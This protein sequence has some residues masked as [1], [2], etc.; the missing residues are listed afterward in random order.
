MIYISKT[1]QILIWNIEQVI[2][3]NP[4]NL[5]IEN[6]IKLRFISKINLIENTDFAIVTCQIELFIINQYTLQIQKIIDIDVF[7]YIQGYTNVFSRY[8]TLSNQ[9]NSLLVSSTKGIQVWTLDLIA[10]DHEYYGIISSTLMNPSQNQIKQFIKHPNYDMIICGGQYLEVQFVQIINAQQL[11]FYQIFLNRFLPPNYNWISVKDIVLIPKDL[12]DKNSQDLILFNFQYGMFQLKANFLIDQNNI[13]QIVNI[14]TQFINNSGLGWFYIPQYQLIVSGYYYSAYLYNIQQQT[15][16]QLLQQSG[17]GNNKR[18][19]ITY[20]NKDYQV[21]IN[22]NGFYVADRNYIG[23][24]V[25]Q[26]QNPPFPYVQNLGS[27]LSV[28]YCDMCFF[29]I[30]NQSGSF[31]DV[32]NLYFMV[33]TAFPINSAYQYISLKQ[34]NLA[35][36]TMPLNLDPYYYENAVWVAVGIYYTSNNS[37]CIFLLLNIYD[38]NIHYC[39]KSPNPNDNSLESVYAIPSLEDSTNQEIVGITRKGIVFRWD[40]KSK[41]YKEQIQIDSLM[42]NI[43]HHIKEDKSIYKYFFAVCETFYTVVLDLQTKQSIILDNPMR[44]LSKTMSMFETIGLVAIGSN[45]G[46]TYLYRY[47][48]KNSNFYLFMQLGANKLIE[49][50]LFVTLI[51]KNVLWIQ[52]QFRYLYYSIDQCLE[53]V[54]NCLNCSFDFYYQTSEAQQGTNYYGQ[55]TQDIPF[56]SSNHLLTAILK[57]Q[58]YRDTVKAVTNIETIINIQT[59]YPFQLKEEFLNFN[60]NQQISL[61]IKSIIKGQKAQIFTNNQL[62]FANYNSINIQDIDFIFDLKNN[63]QATCGFSFNNLTSIVLDNISS[64]GQNVANKINCYQFTVLNSYFQLYNYT[65]QN[66]SLEQITNLINV[67]QS[68][69]IFIQNL[70]IDN[71]KL[72][73]GFSIINSQSDIFFT[74]NNINITKNQPS[75]NF[76]NQSISSLF[77]AGQFNLSDINI[78]F[79]TLINIKIFSAMPSLQQSNYTF[80]IQN[81]NMMENIFKLNSDHILFNALYSQLS[82]PDHNFIFQNG[83]FFRNQ[84]IYQNQLVSLINDQNTTSFLIE[85]INIKNVQLHNINFSN[86]YE[87]SFMKL[88]NAFEANITHYNCFDILDQGNQIK[89]IAGCL[90]LKDIQNT[91]LN[92]IKFY[93]K[94]CKDISLL[95]ITNQQYENTS[96]LITKGVF[97]YLNLQQ[98]QPSSQLN[99]L[100]I[101]SQQQSNITLQYCEFQQNI[102]SSPSSV[103]INSVTSLWI[104]NVLGNTVISNSKF[105]NSTSNSLYNFI[106]IQSS[107]LQIQNCLFDQS[108]FQLKSQLIES[109]NTNNINQQ[110]GFIRAN[111][112][113]LIVQ[114]TSCS[115][116]VSQKGSFIYTE[117]FGQTLNISISNSNFSNGYSVVDGS[118]LY[119]DITNQNFFFTCEECNFFNLYNYQQQSSAIAF[120]NKAQSQLNNLIKFSRGSIQNITGLEYGYFIKVQGLS[121]IFENIQK[122]SNQYAFENNFNVFQSFIASYNSTIQFIGCQIS[123]QKLKQL[124]P[125]LIDS[126]L[127]SV[128]ISQTIFQDSLFAYSFI[129][130]DQGSLQILNSTFKNIQQYSQ[131]KQIPNRVLQGEKLS[132]NSNSLIKILSGTLA[133]RN[134]TLFQSIECNQMCSGSAFQI[135]NSDFSLQNAIFQDLKS[136]Q[137]GAIYIQSPSSVNEID[138]CLFKNN[139]SSQNGGALIILTQ[140]GNKYKIYI[141]N[142]QFINNTSLNGQ[143]GAFYI[144]SDSLNDLN[145]SILLQNSAVTSNKAQQG[146]AL[147]SFN[148]YPIIDPLTIMQNNFAA[149]C[150]QDTFSFPTKLYLA[151][152]D[153]FLLSQQNSKLINDK[154]V[155]SNFKSGSGLQELRFQMFNEQNELFVP[156]NNLEPYYAYVQIS[157]KTVNSNNFYIRGQVQQKYVI[158]EVPQ[159][160]SITFNSL[161]IIGI[162]GSIGI[163][164]FYSNQ[165]FQLEPTTNKFI[166]NQTYEIII[167][168]RNCTAGEYIS[169]YNSYQEC[170]NCPQGTYSIDPKV[171]LNCPDGATCQEGKGIICK[172][173]YWRS[174][175]Y[176]DQVVKCKQSAQNCIGGSYGN[177]ICKKGSIGALCQECDV[178]GSYWEQEQYT[179]ASNQKDCVH[180]SEAKDYIYKLILINLWSL[181]SLVYT[182]AKNEENTLMRRTSIILTKY[183]K[184][185]KKKDKIEKEVKSQASYQTNPMISN[186]IGI[187]IKLFMNYIF[188]ISSLGQLN[189]DLPN[190]LTV[191]PSL[192]GRPVSTQVSSLECF[193]VGYNRN[194][195][196]IY[197]KLIFSLSLPLLHFILFV[198]YLII[199][200]RIDKLKQFPWHKVTTSIL[201]IVIYTQPDLISYMISLSSCIQIGKNK[202]I[203]ANFSYQCY[204]DEDYYKYTYYLVFPC[205]IL[206][207]VALPMA[208]FLIL[209]LNKQRLQRLNLELKFGFIYKEYKINAYYWEFVK[210]FIKIIIILCLNFY[211]Q[212][213]LVKGNLILVSIIFYSYLLKTIKPY[214]EEEVNHIDYMSTLICAISIYLG[215]FISEISDNFTYYQYLAYIIIAII[216]M[217]FIGIIFWKIF[218]QKIEIFYQKIKKL[219]QIF[220]KCKKNNKIQKQINTPS[221]QRFKQSFQTFLKSNP[222]IRKNRL[223]FI[224]NQIQTR[225]L[226][227]KDQDK[228]K[229]KKDVS[230]NIFKVSNEEN[231]MSIIISPKNQTSQEFQIDK[232]IQNDL[233]S[234]NSI[235]QDLNSQSQIFSKQKELCSHRQDINNNSSQINYQNIIDLNSNRT[236]NQESPFLISASKISSQIVKPQTNND[237]N[238]L[239][240]D[241]FQV[242]IKDIN[243]DIL[244]DRSM[245]N[246][247][248][249]N[250]ENE[251]SNRIYQFQKENIFEVYCIQCPNLVTFQSITSDVF[252]FSKFH[253]QYIIGC[254]YFENFQPSNFILIPKTSILILNTVSQSNS[255]NSILYY[256]DLQSTEFQMHYIQKIDQI[257]AWNNE[258]VILAN[259]YTLNPQNQVFFQY[260]NTINLIE[261]SDFAV[262]TMGLEIYIINQYNLSIIKI[263]D[264]Y[265]NYFIYNYWGLYSSFFVLS[266]NENVLLVQTT[267]GIQAWTFDLKS[268]DHEHYG[269]IQQTFQNNQKQFVKHPK[270]DMIII[271]IVYGNNISLQFIQID[272][273]V[274]NEYTQFY[275]YLYQQQSSLQVIGMLIIPKDQNDINSKDKLLVNYSTGILSIDMEFSLDQKQNIQNTF[276]QVYSINQGSS[277]WLYLYDQNQLILGYQFYAYLIDIKTQSSTQMLQYASDGNNRRYIFEYQNSQYYIY[278]NPHGFIVTDRDYNNRR[279]LYKTNPPKPY[280][281]LKHGTFFQ[282]KGCELCYVLICNESGNRYD[283]NNLYI[284][285][286]LAFPINSTYQVKYQFYILENISNINLNKQYISL[287]AHNIQINT[288]TYNLDPFFYNNQVW[289]TIGVSYTQNQLGCVF[290]LLNIQ[291]YNQYFCLSSTN[292][293]DNQLESMFAIVSLNDPNN[294]EIVG[295]TRNGIVFKW[296][297]QNKS[298]TGRILIPNCYDSQSG[299]MYHYVQSDQSIYK[300]FIVVCETFQA[301]ILDLQTEQVKIIDFKMRAMNRVVNVFEQ[302]GIIAFGGNFEITYLFKY[303]HQ[304]KQF[305]LF[306][307]IGSQ[308]LLEQVFFIQLVSQNTLWIQYTFRDLYLPLDTCLQDVN[309]CLNCSLDYYYQITE[310]QQTNKFYGLGTA[311]QPFSSSNNLF[312]GILKAQ[313]YTDNIVGVVNI[314]TNIFINPEKVFQIKNQ[315][316]SFDFNQKIS[317]KIKSLRDGYQA[318]VITLN[319]LQFYNY[320]SITFQD[321]N[322]VFDLQ[323]LQTSTCGLVFKNVQNVVL[324]NIQA[325]AQNLASKSNFYLISVNN[326]FLQLLNYQLKNKIL[327]QITE[328]I[329]IKNSNQVLIQNFTLDSCQLDPGFTIMNSESDIFFNGAQINILNNNTTLS[330]QNQMISALFIAGQYNLTNININN[331]TFGN[332]K[333]FDSIPLQ[334]QVNY[335]FQF[336]NLQM[337]SNQFILNNQNLLFSVLYTQLSQPEHNLFLYNGTFYNN[338][339]TSVNQQNSNSLA[340]SSSAKSY[341]IQTEKIKNIQIRNVNFSNHNEISFIQSLYTS[342]MNISQFNFFSTPTK[343]QKQTTI[344]GCFQVQEIQNIQIV[345]LQVYDINSQD[346][347]L[348]LLENEIYKDA[349]ILIDRS[350]FTNLSLMQLLPSSNANPIQILTQQKS[351]IVFQNCIFKQIMLSSPA[352]ALTYSVTSIWVQNVLGNTTILSSQFYKF[353]SN[354]KYNSLYIQTQSLS[355]QNSFFDEFQVQNKQKLILNQDQSNIIT[356]GGFIRANVYD[357]QMKNISCSNSIGFKGSFIYAESYGQGLS[358]NISDSN[359]TEGYSLSDGSAF[360]FDVS[361]INFQ[362]VCSNCNFKNFFNFQTGSSVIAFSNISSIQKTQQVYINYGLIYNI[363]GYQYGYF[364]KANSLLLSFQ[365][366]SQIRN[367]KQTQSYSHQDQSLIYSYKSKVYFFNC[368]LDNFFMR[369]LNPLLINSQASQITLEKTSLLNSE[370]SSTFISINQGQLN[371]VNSSFNNINQI[372]QANEKRRILQS[373]LGQSVSSNSLIQIINAT[374]QINSDSIFNNL[375]CNQNCYGSSLKI[376]ES[377]FYIQNAFFSNLQAT[378]GGAIYIENAAQNNIISN[379]EFKNNTS[380]LDG[381]ALM[382]YSSAS[383]E[384]QLNVNS[385]KF[386][387]NQSIKGKGGAIYVY[388]DSLNDNNQKIFIVNSN[389]TNNKAQIG[390][391]IQFQNNSPDID[392]KTVIYNNK[393][394]SYGQNTY[395]NPTKLHFINQNDFLNKYPGSKMI[396]DSVL[397]LTNFK[398]GSNL[399]S[400]Y[401]QMVNEQNELVIPQAEENPYYVKVRI[402][403]QID[404]QT[405]YQIRGQQSSKYVINSIPQLSTVQFD[406]IQVIGI[407]GSMGIIEF[408][409]DQ[410]FRVDPQTNQLQQD[411]V[412]KIQIF[413]RNCTAGE[414]IN[415]YSNYQECIYCPIGTYSFDP[416]VCLDCPSGAVCEPGKG[417]TCQ[418]GFWRSSELDNQILECTYSKYNCVG[419][420]YGNHICRRGSIGALCQECDIYGKY[421]DE[422]YTKQTEQN[423]CIPCSESN[424]YLYKLILIQL[425]VIF[426]LAFIVQKNEENTQQYRVSNILIKYFQKRSSSMESSVQE[427]NKKNDVILNKSEIYAKIF[428]NYIFI[429][430]VIGTL[431]L[432]IPKQILLLPNFL[433]KPLYTSVSALECY[434]ASLKTE[435]PPYNEEELLQIEQSS[436]LT[437]AISIYLGVFIGSSDVLKENMQNIRKKCGYLKNK[438]FIKSNQQAPK[439]QQVKLSNKQLQ[440]KI[441]RVLSSLLQYSKEEKKQILISLKDQLQI[442]NVKCQSI[443]QSKRNINNNSLMGNAKIQNSIQSKN[444]KASISDLDEQNNL[445]LEYFRNQKQFKKFKSQNINELLR[446]DSKQ[447]EEDAQTF[448]N[449]ILTLS[450]ASSDQQPIILNFEQYSKQEE[451]IQ[452]KNT[453]SLN[454]QIQNNINLDSNNFN[455]QEETDI[456]IEEQNNL[457]LNSLHRQFNQKELPKYPKYTKKINKKSQSQ[458]YSNTAEKQVQNTFFE[459]SFSISSASSNQ[460]KKI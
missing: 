15:T 405:N 360:Y 451:Q 201:F 249:E 85:N 399:S 314:N 408:Y 183:F 171:C 359:F 271:S 182:V 172:E 40:M 309:N 65:L 177:K 189:L 297:L 158:N 233:G 198:F 117:S 162:P 343:S 10:F 109:K 174:G 260:I 94:T 76:Q 291:D 57:A 141:K 42:G 148:I 145:Q 190:T 313:Q 206:W 373:D 303:D 50:V 66:K 59:S 332:F 238:L 302:I 92:Q 132:Q 167:L 444:I 51:P 443:Q 266:N 159:L 329:H 45:N 55:G 121:V 211:S 311:S 270:Y 378:E 179:K 446:Q 398:S 316:L 232:S 330:M 282:V 151:N 246:I 163:I 368:T 4:Y 82:N 436:T 431:K 370:F 30:C 264:A 345:Q 417:L 229:F 277:A 72:D 458:I 131:L 263:F 434:L 339:Y 107:N 207:I 118:A 255:Q 122:I 430:S 116:S 19:M 307:Q 299:N 216:N 357:L 382:I 35:R 352:S 412:F 186:K 240:S 21:Y 124:Y 108:S 283:P 404:N 18:Y 318:Q 185:E 165:I 348:I 380:I 98:N 204:A 214:K 87:I 453:Q 384:Y 356:E 392:D 312:T 377:T 223:E 89:T 175:E 350:N 6:Q 53:N 335:T 191:F 304:N 95:Q 286:T 336:Y 115:N 358:I 245:P 133:V 99:P 129:T 119:F 100:Q 64:A 52:S 253:Y 379:C 113:N 152:Q 308:K 296:D 3:A 247:P 231:I 196:I 16:T 22:S 83:N 371:I 24:K 280:V 220:K 294:Q 317:L 128:T 236:L 197:L 62:S 363:T 354:S 142:S 54:E 410:I 274:N 144:Y 306:M 244:S 105:Q 346:I 328:L 79:N 293:S 262:I 337:N 429:I 396:N 421:W 88:Q 248:Q 449:H 268:Y 11:S 227:E 456:N 284:A 71:C 273:V 203:L 154:I 86:H 269:Y 135:Q 20:Q 200:S 150:G 420:S 26:K 324:D 166:Q 239:K 2:L 455:V 210:M 161:Q 366:V 395:S 385:C 91:N 235:K 37:G 394:K 416:K 281:Q 460:E 389:I 323:N 208:L 381:G 215:V 44:S 218:E 199:Q 90:L 450:P 29:I 193:L 12:K 439:S 63:I 70:V 390:G 295:I 58:Q 355:L 213:T 301:N 120:N 400:I 168:F 60:F 279:T 388:S 261:N 228:D 137:G 209:F 401:F 365:N 338:S 173:G 265:L 257:L 241:L 155:I 427:E 351:S 97:N 101:I 409:S 305:N 103:L 1:D 106:Y 212:N 230:Q 367:Q 347:S 414:F 333:V 440:L 267:V 126:Q 362:M 437:I 138:N 426:S 169:Q 361:N 272:S 47:D 457:Q 181:A 31:Y 459:N 432:N 407:P 93:N 403:N 48:A 424:E 334:S 221:K 146:G 391:G 36:N 375:S 298:N 153:Q 77:Q 80:Q 290:K 326:G 454:S 43:Y 251:P 68:K 14:N 8:I 157:N 402:S 386:T 164:E 289:V 418:E 322:I 252:N 34:Y 435:V 139:T 275:S 226:E 134:N 319:Q 447:Q 425:F 327:S 369:Q 445:Q 219:L 340:Y 69:Q 419:G 256:I 127:S 300:Y 33:T 438:Y 353:Q 156:S 27:F 234:K 393:A 342:Q 194:I 372:N 143:G 73:P 96:I 411:Y 5:D 78:S 102:L 285:T 81:I 242:E 13:I 423:D 39:L 413:F 75:Q 441:Q 325:T 254:N 74:G 136:V 331:N 364:I 111:V 217:I 288:M 46:L 278:I 341:L 320:N 237:A 41:E 195:P 112:L 49:Q 23:R 321:I 258:Q 114:N 376:Q 187:Y 224:K 56:T 250:V 442:G 315:F 125:L 397:L 130:I 222:E 32:T 149:K 170:V 243:L 406:K 176:D 188:I 225:I 202:Y 452:D 17:D 349:N 140:I 192:F 180:C 276:F 104:Q 25:M 374:L 110:G 428:M 387:E 7:G 205:L 123:N 310:T 67:Q 433:A 28:K 259:P 178:Y 9:Q 147:Y 184:K 160:S 292:P 84:Y 422:K 61:T 344:A 287:S 415:K 38:Q 383:S 448:M